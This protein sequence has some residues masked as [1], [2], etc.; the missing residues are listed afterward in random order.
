[1]SKSIALKIFLN[2]AELAQITRLANGSRYDSHALQLMD[3]I[4]ERIHFANLCTQKT[5]RPSR[6][7][8]S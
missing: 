3:R 7:T 5:S 6:K 1:M 4:V 2:S 8:K